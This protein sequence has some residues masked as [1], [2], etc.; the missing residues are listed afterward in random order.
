M[1]PTTHASRTPLRIARCYS[2]QVL[3]VAFS[4]RGIGEWLWQFAY[5]WGAMF[6]AVVA[7]RLLSRWVVWWW[8]APAARGTDLQRGGSG[9]AQAT[10]SQPSCDGSLS[11][12]VVPCS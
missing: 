3:E 8:A 9:V 11:A 4:P 6:K 12:R 2:G 1:V 5:E 7:A 10:R